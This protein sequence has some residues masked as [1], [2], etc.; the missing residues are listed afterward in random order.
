MYLLI[1]CKL[2]IVYK[3]SFCLIVAVSLYLNIFISIV[4]DLYKRAFIRD[5]IGFGNRSRLN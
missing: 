1:W 3:Y 4:T 2:V 5:K